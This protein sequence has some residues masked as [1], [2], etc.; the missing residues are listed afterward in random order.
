[1]FRETLFPLR[2]LCTVG[3]DGYWSI[4]MD[5]QAR[6]GIVIRPAKGMGAAS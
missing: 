5:L 3:V 4:M 1:M 2:Q 6:V